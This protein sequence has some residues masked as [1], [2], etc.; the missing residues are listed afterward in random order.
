MEEI[1]IIFRKKKKNPKT[2]AATALFSEFFS[3]K[4]QECRG[5]AAIILRR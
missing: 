2:Y 3:K 4:L 5:G 1:I